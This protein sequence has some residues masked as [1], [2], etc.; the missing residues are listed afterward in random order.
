[1]TLKHDQEKC[2]RCA[3]CVGVCP[4]EALDYVN[5]KIVIDHE[6][7]TECGTCVKFCPVIAL[8]LAE[9]E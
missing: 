8:S 7:C 4:F 1:M 5:G 2:I 6:K 9:E 3:G